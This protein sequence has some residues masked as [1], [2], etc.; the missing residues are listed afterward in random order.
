MK[1][2]NP[3]LQIDNTKSHGAGGSASYPDIL[4]GPREP[5]REFIR[6]GP[7]YRELYGLAG[8]LLRFFREASGAEPS[9]C[10]CTDNRALLMAALLASLGGG[11]RVILPYAF[12]TQA[13]IEAGAA[14]S[15]IFF[16]TDAPEKMDLPE[17]ARI[18]TPAQLPPQ[19]ELAPEPR[20]RHESFLVLFTGGSTGTPKIWPKTPE[21]MFAEAFFQAAA[22]GMNKEDIVLSTSP[23]NHIYGLLFSVL[24]PFVSGATVLDGTFL[25][26]REILGAA[27]D[28]RATV[29]LS[30]PAQ[31]RALKAGEPA[32]HNLRMALSSAGMLERQDSEYF[33]EKTGVAVTEIFGS[34][35]TGG[36]A[37][38][39]RP[40][41]GDSWVP[42]DPVRWKI[43]DGRLLV[44]SDF[45]SPTLPR[46]GEGFFTTSDRVDPDGE[47]RFFLRGRIDSV[48]KIGGRRVDLD[49]VQAK[50]K[51][52]SGVRDAYVFAVPVGRGRQNE[53]VAVVET[54]L[55]AARVRGALSAVS[56]PY[57]VPKRLAVVETM[58]MTAAGK[59]DRS[60]IEKLLKKS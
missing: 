58:P 12:S 14:F 38:R 26:P 13:L 32:R 19:G 33:Y 15:P 56:E 37:V 20:D 34:T 35:E 52:I 5:D 47:S 24:V 57:A 27:R 1:K 9:V 55:S 25:F 54:D 8:R 51:R 53:P 21:N 48:V 40:R 6:N 10:L 4:S 42:M 18:V 59:Y 16:L 60:E 44:R 11:P 43:R 41:D 39:R 36:I 31:Y 23:C 45:L 29:L 50:L 28:F 3:E 46:D 22:L 2:L 30:V 7:T 49:E 17:G